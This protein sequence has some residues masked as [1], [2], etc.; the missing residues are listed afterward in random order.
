MFDVNNP[1]PTHNMAT[2]I[3]ERFDDFLLS[4]GIMLAS[5][6][7]EEARERKFSNGDDVALYGTEFGEILDI[8]EEYLI[9]QCEKNNIPYHGYV[10]K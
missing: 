9:D 8:I 3:V 4:H 2:D 10:Y 6:D 7:P 5:K 1:V